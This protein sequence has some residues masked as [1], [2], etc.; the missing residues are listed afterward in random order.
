[1]KSSARKISFV[2]AVLMVLTVV[3]SIPFTVSADFSPVETAGMVYTAKNY[4]EKG[5]KVTPLLGTPVSG[6][7][8]AFLFG[9]LLGSGTYT[10]GTFASSEDF[11]ENAA[12]Y[13]W[14]EYSGTH[15][16]KADFWNNSCGAAYRHVTMTG[17][18]S[19]ATLSGFATNKNPYYNWNY[20]NGFEVDLGAVYSIGGYVLHCYN[21]N[22]NNSS[23]D[24]YVSA[25][26][27]TWSMISTVVSFGAAL[28]QRGAVEVS[29]TFS[30]RAAGELDQS[31]QRKIYGSAEANIRFGSAVEAR[32]IRV[33]GVLPNGNG[34]TNIFSGL[35]VYRAATETN[36]RG[37][38][39]RYKNDDVAK[40]GIRFTGEFNKN[41][42]TG[43]G[44]DD[45]NF[46]MILMSA[47]QYNTLTDGEKAD[48]TSL[49]A[50][51]HVD[52]TGEDAVLVDGQFYRI[53]AI[54]YNIADSDLDKDIVAITYVDDHVGEVGVRSI[55]TVAKRV[56]A[57]GSGES[58]AAIE[59]CQ[60]IVD[61]VES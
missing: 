15:T 36:F 41:A 40:N 35:E 43:A 33:L 31:G 38:G 11:L 13:Q 30:T 61:Q 44:T 17:N 42:V 51:K 54:I 4:R 48:L 26:G 18:A 25:D 28:E 3:L 9:Y 21:N 34:G 20:Q 37:A 8:Y 27:E 49:R 19:A 1:M 55:Y 56:V 46:G 32:Y 6:Y 57:P 12:P 14:V 58:A 7:N 23:F 16:T 5:V 60:G 29:G 2:L 59:Y 10:P 50:K 47:D 24:F 52:V 39:I 45:A 53:R 22:A